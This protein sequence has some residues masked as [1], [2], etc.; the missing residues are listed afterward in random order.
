MHPPRLIPLTLL[1]SS[2]SHISPLYPPPL[3]CLLSFL[4]AVHPPPPPGA[5]LLNFLSYFIHPSC[6]FFISSSTLLP[7][8]FINLRR[9]L[10][11]YLLFISLFTLSSFRHY[12]SL[13]SITL[14][15]PIHLLCSSSPLL[16]T[17]TLFYL[18]INLRFLPP[19]ALFFLNSLA[20]SSFPD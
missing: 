9:C 10:T 12:L 2:F 13:P 15:T 18:H 3:F 14:V 17:P 8:H 19:Y 1:P 20:F 5:T 11:P 6:P 16:Y 4:S 7:V